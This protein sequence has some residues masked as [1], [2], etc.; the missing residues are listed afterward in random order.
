MKTEI[1]IEVYTFDERVKNLSAEIKWYQD[2]DED[3]RIYDFMEDLEIAYEEKKELT[4]KN[5]G[6]EGGVFFVEGWVRGRKQDTKVWE[7]VFAVNKEEARSIFVEND[8]KQ[9]YF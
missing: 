3:E 4:Q 9:K 6:R 5:Q 2:R 8:K 1:R 7:Y